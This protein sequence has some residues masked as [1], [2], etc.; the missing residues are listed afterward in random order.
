MIICLLSGDIDATE[1]CK[2]VREDEDLQAVKLIALAN[3]LGDAE[4]TALIQKG[5]DGYISKN[6]PVEEIVRN[7]EQATAIIY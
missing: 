7:I 6:T 5:F 3:N 2:S 1:I 4:Q